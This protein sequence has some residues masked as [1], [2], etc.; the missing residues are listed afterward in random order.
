MDLR[1]SV[2]WQKNV[3]PTSMSNKKQGIN[4]ATKIRKGIEV[5]PIY[6]GV[7]ARAEAYET[8]PPPDKGVIITGGKVQAPSTIH[9]QG[10]RNFIQT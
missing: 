9:L 8:P 3:H 4:Q 10:N 6:I 7:E 5:H 2:H 1:K